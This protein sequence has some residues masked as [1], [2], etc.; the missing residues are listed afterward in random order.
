VIVNLFC[1]SLLGRSGAVRA[2]ASCRGCGVG[3]AGAF[4]LNAGCRGGREMLRGTKDR[5][6]EAGRE[7]SK[8][9]IRECR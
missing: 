7:R 8:A 5:L 1:V 6:E 2:L 4:G 3:G 9:L